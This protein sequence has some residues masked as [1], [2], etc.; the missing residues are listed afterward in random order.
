MYC[1]NC[2]KELIGSAEICISC[3]FRSGNGDKFCPNCGTDVAPGQ[4]MCVKCGFMLENAPQQTT[5]SAQTTN[6]KNQV[7]SSDYK[8]YTQRVR[9]SKICATIIQIISLIAVLALL[10]LPIYKYEFVPETFEDALEVFEGVEDWENIEKLLTS[11]GKIEKEFSLVE[12]IKIILSGLTLEDSDSPLMMINLLVG[13]FPIFEVIMGITLICMTIPQLYKTIEEIRDI[14]K[15]TLLLFNEIRK[16]GSTN[17]KENI[18]KKQT[19]VSIFLYTIMDVIFAPIYG[20]LMLDLPT[21]NT[22][23]EMRHM[24]NFSGITSYAY[25]VII[26]FVAYLITSA[27]KKRI[28]ANILEEITREEYEGQ[29]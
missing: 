5:P 13:I 29:A 1:R 18:L 3:G 6:N 11:E 16:S 24:L 19:L 4:S 8:K 12:D 28:E 10:F 26:L 2:G 20:R 17:K 27:I 22:K 23:I 25:I 15:S 9:K 7:N 14:D 21:M